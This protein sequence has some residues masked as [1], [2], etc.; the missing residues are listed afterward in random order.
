MTDL[1]IPILDGEEWSLMEATDLYLEHLKNGQSQGE[2]PNSSS[3]SEIDQ[4]ST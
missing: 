1:D 2:S 3:L 4:K